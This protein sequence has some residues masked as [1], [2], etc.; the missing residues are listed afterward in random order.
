M[1]VP[2][3]GRGEEVG[4]DARRAIHCE[5]YPTPHIQGIGPEELVVMV[6]LFEGEL[7]KRRPAAIENKPSVMLLKGRQT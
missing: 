3:P 4:K 1:A 2:A 5:R 6:V 7:R